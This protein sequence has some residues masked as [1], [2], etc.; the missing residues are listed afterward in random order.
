MEKKKPFVLCEHGECLRTAGMAEALRSKARW[1]RQ[2]APPGSVNT[3]SR[4]CEECLRAGLEGKARVAIFGAA[5]AKNCSH[6]RAHKVDGMVRAPSK[7]KALKEEPNDDDEPL[8]PLLPSWLP[9]VEVHEVVAALPR[10]LPKEAAA[11][12]RAPEHLYAMQSRADKDI[13]KIG[14]S[15][16]PW[17]RRR[18]LSS[19]EG[20]SFMLRAIWRKEWYLEKALLLRLELLTPD[21]ALLFK[22]K[23]VRSAPGGLRQIHAILQEERM[24]AAA[25]LTQKE[26][27]PP[28]KRRR[29]CDD[30][31]QKDEEKG[32]DAKEEEKDDEEHEEKGGEDE[33]GEVGEQKGDDDEK[34]SGLFV[35]F[36]GAARRALLALRIIQ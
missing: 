17:E 21:A 5:G 23:E 12:R 29:R 11:S 27:N 1:C 32:E 4:R 7:S 34:D 25:A 15:S 24:A 14:V 20:H 36:L 6:C 30:E 16:D 13:W 31:E 10:G 18:R 19:S 33:D 22:T 2:H 26:N 8:V 35:R 9:V 28:K 3:K